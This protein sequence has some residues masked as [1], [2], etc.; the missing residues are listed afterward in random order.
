MYKVIVNGQVYT[1]HV[2]KDAKDAAIKLYCALSV[3]DRLAA[4]QIVVID[5]RDNTTIYTPAQL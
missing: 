3:T 4:R 5:D 1:I 2:A